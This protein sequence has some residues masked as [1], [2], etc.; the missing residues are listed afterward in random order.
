[1]TFIISILGAQQSVSRA[2]RELC[3]EHEETCQRQSSNEGHAHTTNRRASK[4]GSSRSFLNE[5][6][7]V[8]AS[9][10]QVFEPLPFPDVAEIGT[11]DWIVL[12]S[13]HRWSFS[14]SRA[15]CTILGR[16]AMNT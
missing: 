10:S 15:H 16:C 7:A 5:K 4:P 13:R 11:F 6:R 1:M 3:S 12:G 2:L 14:P 8:T 9:L